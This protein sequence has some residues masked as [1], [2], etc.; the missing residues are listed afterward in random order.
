MATNREEHLMSRQ[1]IPEQS[2]IRAIPG[3]DLQV[4]VEQCG[5]VTQQDG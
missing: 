2:L 5:A 3:A 1:G 4:A